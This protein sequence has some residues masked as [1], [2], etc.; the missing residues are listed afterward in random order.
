[1]HPDFVRG[2][3]IKPGGKRDSLP[4]V[5]PKALERLEEDFGGNVLRRVPVLDA[6]KHIPENGGIVLLEE[7]AEC[8]GVLLR[9]FDDGALVVQIRLCYAGRMHVFQKVAQNS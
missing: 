7:D 8:F 4:P 6:A 2:D 9:A 5:S 1:M 3:A